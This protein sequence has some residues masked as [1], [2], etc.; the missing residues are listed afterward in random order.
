VDFHFRSTDA[1]KTLQPK[2]LLDALYVKGTAFALGFVDL[3]P[4]ELV[5]A[6]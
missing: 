1:V 6:K 5:S 2:R 3:N 4:P